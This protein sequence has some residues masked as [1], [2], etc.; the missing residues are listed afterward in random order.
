MRRLVSEMAAWMRKCSASMLDSTGPYASCVVA[1]AGMETTTN[2]RRVREGRAHLVR[3]A[4]SSPLVAQEEQDTVRRRARRASWQ[5]APTDECRSRMAALSTRARLG[6]RRGGPTPWT[7]RT[8]PR[9]TPPCSERGSGRERVLDRGRRNP[10]A[11]PSRRPK[12]RARRPARAEERATG[13]SETPRRAT[14]WGVVPDRSRSG[15][16]RARA[17]A[18]RAPWRATPAARI[19]DWPSGRAR[20]VEP[21]NLGARQF[22]DRPNPD[23][24]ARAHRFQ[25]V[26]ATV[27]RPRRSA[28]RPTASER[29]SL[30]GAAG[31][32]R[33]S[34]RCSVTCGADLARRPVRVATVFIDAIARRRASSAA[35]LA[36]V[37]ARARAAA[38]V[39]GSAL[40]SARF[41][42][43]GAPASPR[44]RRA[45]AS[46]ATPRV[47][48]GGISLVG[49]RRTTSTRGRVHALRAT[50]SGRDAGTA[51][52]S[53][54]ASS[55]TDGGGR[56][57]RGRA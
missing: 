19:S 22:S 25:T 23:A 54:S 51:T 50:P 49:R 7:P 33:R 30:R 9:T 8:P 39:L 41:A 36:R 16:E 27:R 48:L 11:R 46:R 15:R 43:P 12:R 10:M 53:S 4:G 37:D 29:T 13:G 38:V 52:T 6:R 35:T 5:R 1:S 2:R 32:H 17:R 47:V 24:R 18:G 42:S 28:G 26:G 20:G 56:A 34:R 44:A 14:G 3:R 45:R 40:A 55:W 57:A 31:D 21:A